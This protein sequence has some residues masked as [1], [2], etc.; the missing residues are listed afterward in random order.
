MLQPLYLIAFKVIYVKTPVLLYCSCLICT[1]YVSLGNINVVTN[2]RIG[3]AVYLCY[4]ACFNIHAVQYLFHSYIVKDE[5]IFVNTE[6][7]FPREYRRSEIAYQIAFSC[8][9]VPRSYIICSTL[10][11]CA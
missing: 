2:C 5:F 11:G 4:V 1:V 8:R 6:M 10:I 7:S 9:K 3:V